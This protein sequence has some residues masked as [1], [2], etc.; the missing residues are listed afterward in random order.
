MIYIYIYIYKYA[1]Y[2]YIYRELEAVEVRWDLFA[3]G[4][5]PP[6]QPVAQRRASWKSTRRDP[7]LEQY[8][9]SAYIDE[10]R[11]RD[12]PMQMRTSLPAQDS[13]TPDGI[14]GATPTKNLI[15]GGSC[16]SPS[17]YNRVCSE[18]SCPVCVALAEDTQ[19]MF[20]HMCV[21]IYIERERE[22]DID[23]C[24]YVYVYIY[25]ERERYATCIQHI[26]LCVYIYIHIHTHICVCVCVV[27]V[28]MLY[29][30]ILCYFVQGKSTRKERGDESR[31]REEW[32]ATEW[33]FSKPIRGTE[34]CAKTAA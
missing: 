1:V 22:I 23:V 11:W 8:P 26:Y 12:C 4:H 5:P 29:H 2:I 24:I 16:C 21:Y 19:Y 32:T 25:I 15:S 13:T 27:C 20:I 31:W 28:I 7:K 6:L 14:N 34:P 9:G 30:V 17:V 10:Q 33:R 3:E 18:V